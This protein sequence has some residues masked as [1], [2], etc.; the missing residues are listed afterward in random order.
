MRYSFEAPEAF[1]L[2]SRPERSSFCPT[3]V[4]TATTSAPG[5][6]SLSQGMMMEVSNPPE[7]ART[8]FFT[9]L[10]SL[11]SMPPL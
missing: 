3:S 2:A 7:Y 9:L 4:Q 1:A 6:L 10:P 8:I 5:Y 11:T